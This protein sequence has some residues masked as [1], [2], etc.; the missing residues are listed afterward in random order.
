V[1]L[2]P[3]LTRLDIILVHGTWGRGFF[4]RR[5][6]A[7]WCS[8]N[9]TFRNGLLRCLNDAM[10]SAQS[11]ISVFNWSGAN[12]ILARAKAAD[13]LAAFLKSISSAGN[14]IL[15]I[16][17]SHG[18]NI[19]IRAVGK[20]D[21]ASQVYLCTLATPFFRLFDSGREY[22]MS[23]HI[24]RILSVG[25]LSFISNGFYSKFLSGLSWW[26]MLTFFMLNLFVCVIGGWKLGTLAASSFVFISPVSPVVTYGQYFVFGIAAFTLAA[27]SVIRPVFGRELAFGALRCDAT[28]ESAP[29]SQNATIETLPLETKH[30]KRIVH[31]VYEN[32]S[33]PAN[34][35]R[36]LMA[37]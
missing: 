16:A 5:S 11:S 28:Y 12:S 17:H 34:I 7:P 25:F 26:A 32:A 8:E 27:P 30:G 19:A 4:R 20:L 36:W 13:E 14:S 31:A 29:D 3:V 18:G 23:E 9:S 22:V 33:A 15:I 24:F 35:L 1:T 37:I 6:I 21:D 10:P 2:M